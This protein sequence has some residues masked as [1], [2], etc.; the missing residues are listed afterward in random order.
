MPHLDSRALEVVDTPVEKLKP[1]G[2]NPRTITGA[3]LEQL[4]AM[5]AASPEMLQARPLIALLDGT[6]IAGNQRL[7]AAQ[8]LG[9][10]SI[11]AVFADLDEATAIEWAFRDNNPAGETDP[12]LAAQLLAELEAR[13]R[14]LDM[15]GF[16]PV[17]L[18]ALLRR[19][20]P[21]VDP[22]AVPP[23]PAKPRSKRGEVYELGPHRMM[24]GDA[25]SP[26]TCAC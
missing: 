17:E 21:A 4:K 25:T 5:L 15:T 23:V 1:W 19:I 22:D 9:W 7:A 14:P 8:A 3:R 6:V 18:S 12:D 26:R 24:C 2:R 13:G 16:A 10:S 11:P 20:A